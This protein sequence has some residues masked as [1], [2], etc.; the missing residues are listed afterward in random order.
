MIAFVS[1]S[2]KYSQFSSRGVG[3]KSQKKLEP[4]GLSRVTD[5]WD[6][7]DEAE[8]VL[9]EIIGVG[10][11]QKIVKYCHGKDDRPVAPDVRKSIGAEVSVLLYTFY[12]LCDKLQYL[13]LIILCSATMASGSMGL[14]GLTI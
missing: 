9:G 6:L 7:G 1:I 3:W 12:C 14:T 10:N 13:I 8:T 5:V 4:R 11:A 2:F